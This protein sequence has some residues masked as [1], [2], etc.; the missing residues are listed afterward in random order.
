MVPVLLPAR[1][2]RRT[3]GETAEVASTVLI[4]VSHLHVEP[5]AKAFE[6]CTALG[7]KM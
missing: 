4:G 2:V 1:G 5:G 7:E 6:R 3:A